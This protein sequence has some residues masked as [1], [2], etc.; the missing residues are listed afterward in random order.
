VDGHEGLDGL[1]VHVELA[2]VVHGAAGVDV[3]VAQGGLK[4]GGEPQLE[5]VGGLDVVVA[6]AEDGGFVWEFYVVSVNEGVAALGQGAGDDLNVFHTGGAELGGG[7]FGGVQDVDFVLR[8][9]G[10]AGDAD[11]FEEFF[12][13]AGGVGVNVGADGGRDVAKRGS[14]HAG[15]LILADGGWLESLVLR[16]GLVVVH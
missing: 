11:E 12:E 2:F 15:F 9:C 16:D 3:A 13:E 1:D 10:D 14:G 6:V 8:E 4:G 7:E 5:R